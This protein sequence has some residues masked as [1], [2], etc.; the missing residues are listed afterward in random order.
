MDPG[1]LRDIALHTNWHKVAPRHLRTVT[2]A[3]QW[4]IVYIHRF[5]ES[6]REWRPA[7]GGPGV[8]LGELRPAQRL[9]AHLMSGQ[10][11]DPGCPG[12]FIDGERLVT[13]RCD[14]C[15]TGRADPL[16]FDDTIVLLPEALL[17][18]ALANPANFHPADLRQAILDSIDGRAVDSIDGRADHGCAR[19]GARSKR[20]DEA[21]DCPNCGKP[22]VERVEPL[23]ALLTGRCWEHEDCRENPDT[24]GHTCWRTR[25]QESLR[26]PPNG[27]TPKAAHGTK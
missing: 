9:R 1:R 16:V 25:L 5:D 27:L 19:C 23:A 10:R 7:G 14:D 18:L 15:S 6:V 21:L 11:C 22:Y 13:T 4:P 3:I 2:T 24:L 26:R 8:L 17:A 20:H 12:W